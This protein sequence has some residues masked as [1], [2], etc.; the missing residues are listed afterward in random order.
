MYCHSKLLDYIDRL[1]IQDTVIAVVWKRGSIL[2]IAKDITKTLKIKT[3]SLATFEIELVKYLHAKLLTLEMV[4]AVA[5]VEELGLIASFS[6]VHEK[7]S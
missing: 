4:P 2:Q 5:L 3:T 7:T 1:K 6:A